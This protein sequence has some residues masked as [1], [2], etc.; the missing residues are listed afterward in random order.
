MPLISSLNFTEGIFFVALP[1][2]KNLEPV[3]LSVDVGRTLFADDTI[4]CKKIWSKNHKRKK[5]TKNVT[6]GLL[7]GARFGLVKVSIA[8]TIFC[9]F[10]LALLL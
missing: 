1:K 2:P 3:D 6:N 10:G 5:S 9:T 4:R 7:I 8:A